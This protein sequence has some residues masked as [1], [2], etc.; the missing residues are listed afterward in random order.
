MESSR[1]LVKSLRWTMTPKKYQAYHEAKRFVGSIDNQERKQ[2]RNMKA[3]GGQIL[4][5][6]YTASLFCC[7]LRFTAAG[8]K[9]SVNSM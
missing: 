1:L 2:N 8:V 5:V 4:I 9:L 3:E 6:E 7:L